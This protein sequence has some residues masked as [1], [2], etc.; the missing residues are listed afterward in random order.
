MRPITGNLMHNALALSAVWQWRQDDVLLHALPI[1]HVHGLFVATNVTLATGAAMRWM[2][3]WDTA[4]ALRQL[5]SCT[6]FMGVPTHYGRMLRHADFEPTLHTAAL[7]I[8]TSGSA[9]LPTELANAWQAAV[10]WLPVERYG[11]SETGMN[12]S[13]PFEPASGRCAGSVGGPLPGVSV[14]VAKLA[15][16]EAP[17][18]SASSETTPI[19]AANGGALLDIDGCQLFAAEAEPV[20]PAGVSPAGLAA[21]PELACMGMP[22]VLQVR[23]PNVF[24]GYWRKPEKSAAEFSADGWFNTGDIATIQQD[25][26][27]GGP[28]VRI[29]G[30]DKDMIISGGLNVYPVEIERV[31]D[32]MPGVA[33]CAVIGVPHPDFGEAVVAIV[34]VESAAA[35]VTP[36]HVQ[37]VAREHL[38]AFKVPKLV[39]LQQHE[40][41]RN[42]MGKVQKAALRAEHANAFQ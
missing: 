4:A 34:Q 22:G 28:V 10:G 41:P 3:A 18:E 12:T 37:H 33:E 5:P 31:I 32:A 1:Y 27:D 38:A 23:G 36:E 29:V 9:P 14:R 13:N 11:M 40:L 6:A 39:L 24:S 16:E 35:E 17:A 30:R 25:G 8:A 21:T 7:R 19:A 42:A 20:Y 2:P 26:V 15:S